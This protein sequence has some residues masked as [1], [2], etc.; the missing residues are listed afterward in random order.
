ML[1]T[2]NT[3]S[4]APPVR[5]QPEAANF[6]H[7]TYNMSADRSFFRAP[8]NPEPP[9]GMYYEVPKTPPTDRPPPIFPW[10]KHQSKASRVFP[11]D[12]PPKPAPSVS[13]PSITTDS[14]D[15]ASSTSGPSTP[16]NPIASPGSRT[17]AWDE[18][19]EINRY[20][21]NLPQ[22]RRAKVQVLLNNQLQTPPGMRTPT[23]ADTLQSPSLPKED[24][25]RP[26]IKLT[27]F[28][29]EVERPSLPVTPAPIRRPSFWGAERDAA[30]DLP[31]AEGV[32]S[33]SD[34]NPAERLVELA[35]RQSKVL[36]EGNLQ[37]AGGR[38]IPDREVLASASKPE[39]ISEEREER[40]REDREETLIAA[41]AAAAARQQATPSTTALSVSG[42]APGL[43]PVPVFGTLDFGGAG[44]PDERQVTGS[45]DEI[46]VGPDV[47]T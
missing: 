13:T 9:K 21:S 38:S 26:S 20:I 45:R 28:P 5:S 46:E 47:G 1:E 44:A 3:I 32:P 43:Q 18:M 31:P 30:G 33:Q 39:A 8:Q 42:P 15:E 40:E 17:N 27:D 4:Q 34:W 36:E 19:P 16:T 7:K 24:R 41:A 6:P 37:T 14:N 11:D 10:E 35:R 12:V 2:D 22:N 29:T 25:R 23:G